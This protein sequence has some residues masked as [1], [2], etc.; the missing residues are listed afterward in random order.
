[1]KVAAL[2]DFPY[3]QKDVGTFVRYA[4]LCDTLARACDL[5]VISTNSLHVA[6]QAEVRA[7]PYRV[8]DRRELKKIN[9]EHGLLPPA[10]IP[11]AQAMNVAAIRHICTTEDFDAVLTPYFNR[12]W[13][14]RHLPDHIVRII[15]TH[16]CQSQRTR[17]FARHDLVPTFA[18]TPEQEGAEL[19]KYDIA[20]AMSD[21]DQAEFAAITKR[22]IVTAPFRLKA[23][24]VYRARPSGSEL[25]FIAAK[26]QINDLTLEYLLS[27]VMPLV[28]RDTNLHVVGNVTMPDKVPKGLR[29]QRHENVADVSWIYGAV[30]L[31]LNPTYAG[32]G[33]KTKT[34]EAIRFG[35]PILTSD[36]GAR[37]MRGLLPDDLIVNDKER[38][39]YMIRVLLDDPARREALSQEMLSRL[40]A[41]DSESW[42]KPFVH[43]LRAQIARKREEQGR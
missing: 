21:E 10:G 38:M 32:G 31:A 30:D 9:E 15:D 34:L 22:P 7:L 19:D 6:Q 25:L 41:E 24:P 27:E 35:V 4:S 28:G 36:E 26:S 40:N 17:S 23:K 16:D 3:W 18:M 20:L 37:G 39:A 29:I 42:L 11:A 43:I 1:M 33:V 2:C 8:V 12:E 5:T 14:I 13:M